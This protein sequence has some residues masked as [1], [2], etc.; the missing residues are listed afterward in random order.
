VD[1]RNSQDIDERLREAELEIV[2]RRPEHQISP[3]L[4]RIA[5]LTSMLGAPERAVPL[6]HVTGTNGKTS[7]ARTIDALLR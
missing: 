4:D 1:R 5:T 3:T 2:G 6:I 7:M